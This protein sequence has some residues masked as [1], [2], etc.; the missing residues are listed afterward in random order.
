MLFLCTGDLFSGYVVDADA[1]SDQTAVCVCDLSLSQFG[2]RQ[3]RDDTLLSDVMY[4][5]LCT[6]FVFFSSKIQNA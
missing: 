1:T 3:F 5:V 2:W 4:R 6:S